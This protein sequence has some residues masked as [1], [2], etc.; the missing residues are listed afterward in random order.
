MPYVRTIEMC[1]Y[2]VVAGFATPSLDPVESDK[3]IKPLL[4]ETDEFKTMQD[5]GERFG[6]LERRR[7][8]ILGVAR[9]HARKLD[10]TAFEEARKAYE[11]IV[12]EQKAVQKQAADAKP[13]LIA[14]RLELIKK[15]GVRFQLRDVEKIDEETSDML[16]SK[17]AGLR[18]DEYLLID[19]TTKKKSEIETEI[20]T[21]RIAA[22]T[23]E[24]KAQEKE[25]LLDQALKDTV[26]KR[27]EYEI[28]NRTDAL[29]DAQAWY[30]ERCEE[31]ENRY[32]KKGT[33]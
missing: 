24:E 11:A 17:F 28:Q 6:V 26:I 10:K 18:N 13:A 19:G 4:E 21:E 2:R 30:K 20:E 25:Q 16:T 1:G 27:Y 15:H 23:E 3:A 29:A 14:K 33:F 31:I 32:R 12:E 8:E 7:Q 9:M 22:L 5:L